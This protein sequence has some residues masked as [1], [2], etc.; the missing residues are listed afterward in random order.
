MENNLYS[1]HA[2]QFSNTR[3]SAWGGWIKFIAE[4]KTKIQSPTRIL[5][6]GCGNGR[7]F[8]FS[9]ENLDLKSYMG[10]DYSNILLNIAKQKIGDQK[11]GLHF[12]NINLNNEKWELG[13]APE[14]EQIST[15]R[16]ENQ[17]FDLIVAF[18]LQHHFSSFE[19]RKYF[20]NKIND[21]LSPEGIGVVTYWQFLDY[22][23]YQK[24]VKA[25]T[26]KN[27]YSM[28]FGGNPNV[29]FCHYTDLNEIE[30]LESE[31]KL[32]LI[33]SYRADGKD[34]TEN[35]YRIYQRSKS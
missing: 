8:E 16:I 33:G 1:T 21:L 5:D 32:S 23:R 29:R 25:L 14:K 7:F 9:K 20:L 34:N 27:D 19:I 35:I 2:E 10:V 15:D 13:N 3:K 22:P 4:Y 26:G 12:L 11:K 24:K 18:G 17:R 31:S 28:G 30:K 6:L